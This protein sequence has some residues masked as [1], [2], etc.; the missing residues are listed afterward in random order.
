MDLDTQGLAG[1]GARRGAV[2]AEEDYGRPT[3]EGAPLEVLISSA[4]DADAAFRAGQRLAGTEE[5]CALVGGFGKDQALALSKLAEEREILFINIGSADDEL[6]DARCE[7]H[8]FH[9]EAS[10]SMYL[11]ALVGAQA[12]SGS[13]GW[14][15]LHDSSD[16][17]RALYRRAQGSLARWG[18][19]E[20]GSIALGSPSENLRA[21]EAI[22][23]S[24]AQ[25][26]LLLLDWRAQLDFLGHY[27]AQGL[28]QIVSGFPYPV[29]QTRDFLASLVRAA[30]N[31]GVAARISLWE[32]AGEPEAIEL[33]ERFVARWGLPIDPPAWAA[34]VSVGMLVEAV[35]RSGTLQGAALASELK[36][37]SG[38][39]NLF[40]EAGTSFRPNDQ[41]L[42]QSLF[43]V[44]PDPQAQNLREIVQVIDELPPEQASAV[45]EASDVETGC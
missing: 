27:E 16:E 30:P 36:R 11:D 20:V 9:V 33:G 28:S 6:R 31:S 34:Y 19:S 32:P 22:S 4:P 18:G 15:L 8:T 14:F 37:S 45:G 25:I 42:R 23:Q 38:S 13:Q 35:R 40:K 41:Q 29:T 10:A 3:A 26:V 39:M 2:M 44:R 5:V 7:S 43:V 21:L 1:E 17:G 12:D 24:D